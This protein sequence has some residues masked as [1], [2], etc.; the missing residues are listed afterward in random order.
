MSRMLVACNGA[1]TVP[2]SVI[3]QL[4]PVLCATYRRNACGNM[5]PVAVRLFKNIRFWK[6]DTSAQGLDN[7]QIITGDPVL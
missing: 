1:H 2:V 4:G 7:Y 5:S 6:R 3:C